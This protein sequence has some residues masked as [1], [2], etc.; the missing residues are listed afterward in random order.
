MDL[1]ELEKLSVDLINQHLPNTDWKFEFNNSKRSFGTFN[2]TDKNINISRHIAVLNDEIRVKDTI[3]H[4]IAHALCPK[5][6]H[7][8]IWKRKAR[9]IGACGI[10]CYSTDETDIKQNSSVKVPL[11][12][13]TLICP[14]CKREFQ[15]NRRLKNKKACHT[16]CKTLNYGNYSERFV[17]LPKE[18][19]DCN[20]YLNT[21]IKRKYLYSKI[22][23]DS[24]NIIS[25]EIS[26]CKKRVKRLEDGK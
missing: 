1:N 8:N 15:F 22:M 11:G 9:E 10:R 4:E 6:G 16:C 17:L 14:N 13:Y 5:Q 23:E 24:L 7:N 3:L 26:D 12:K 2:Y 21:I 25:N 18:I 19:K 20:I